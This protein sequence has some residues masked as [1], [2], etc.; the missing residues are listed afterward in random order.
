[1]NNLLRT[2]VRVRVLSSSNCGIVSGTSGLRGLASTSG[3]SATKA[4]SKGIPDWQFYG[5]L[6]VIAGITTIIFKQMGYGEKPEQQT[7]AEKKQELELMFA[8]AERE[9]AKKGETSA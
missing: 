1:M 9:R 4:K 3:S 5:G 2:A 6:S 7:L 8:A